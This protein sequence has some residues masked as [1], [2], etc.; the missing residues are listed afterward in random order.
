MKWVTTP[1]KLALLPLALLTLAGFLPP[2]SVLAVAAISL[3]PSLA[4]AF[5]MLS[6]L[7]FASRSLRLAIGSL[8]A[9]LAI[10]AA[11]APHFSTAAPAVDN[12]DVTVIWAN[13]FQRPDA[14]HATFALAEEVRADYVII[15]EMPGSVALPHGWFDRCPDGTVHMLARSPGPS[16]TTIS[17]PILSAADCGRGSLTCRLAERRP[18]Q[19]LDVTAG[20]QTLT[21]VGAHLTM[22]LLGRGAVQ[23]RAAELAAISIEPKAH[24]TLVV[25]DFN[26]VPWSP[27]FQSV[28]RESK[29]SRI[30]IGARTTWLSPFLFLGLPIDHALS[31]DNVTASVVVGEA[32][33]SDHRPLIVRA[34]LNR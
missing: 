10:S 28:Q 13:V 11:L 2:T 7:L 16:C 1:A 18:A 31:S 25:G 9:S 33:G 20:G 30:E 32:N 22:P 29:L 17:G 24:P 23:E 19:K 15:G 27:L 6:L 34:R 4:A 3:K 14:A 5:F 26:T 12:P 21:L 8:C